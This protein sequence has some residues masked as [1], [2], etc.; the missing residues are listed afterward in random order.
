[1][2][3]E[4]IDLLVKASIISMCV[5]FTMDGVISSYFTYKSKTKEE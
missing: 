4:W 1:M 5:G 3:G 2:F